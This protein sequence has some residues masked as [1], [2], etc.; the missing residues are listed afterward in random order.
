MLIDIAALLLIGVTAGV[1]AGLLGIGGGLVIVPALTTLL[2]MQGAPLEVAM[3]VAIATSLG[4]MLMTS[5]SAVWFHD[6]RNAIDWACVARLAPTMA[7]GALMGGLLAA[8]LP[9]R[10]LALIFAGL[11]LILGLRM[12]MTSKIDNRHARAFPRYWWL[13]GPGIGLVSSLMGIGGGSFNVPYLARNGFPMVQA[14][15]IA[16]ACGWPIA[17]GGV[18]GFTLMHPGETLW[19]NLWGYFYLPGLFLI[20][21]AGMAAAPLGVRMAHYLPTGPLKR[22][23]GVLLML[24]ALRL[25][26]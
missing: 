24:V 9:G 18:I 17:L 7:L 1:L 4:T 19:P 6:K 11:A 25:I 8:W 20:G 15:A 10:V 26:W 12:L 23:F 13:A 2:R 16:S 14:I 22:I 5:A 3:P 21:I